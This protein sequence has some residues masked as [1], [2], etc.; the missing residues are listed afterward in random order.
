VIEKVIKIE[1]IFF[2][3]VKDEDGMGRVIGGGGVNL[4]F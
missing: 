3:V 2:I 4:M 1:M